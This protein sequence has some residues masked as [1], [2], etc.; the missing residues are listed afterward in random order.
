VSI[1]PVAS[2]AQLLPA[3]VV[4][5]KVA[6][7]AIG[8]FADML[9]AAV[10]F[11]PNGSSPVSQVSQPPGITVLPT[12]LSSLLRDF[13]SSFNQLLKNH[14]L[15][16]G[17]GVRLRLSELGDV[18]VAGVHPRGSVIQNLLAKTPQ[19]AELFR[20]IAA[21]ATAQRKAQEFAAFQENSRG[22]GDGFPQVFSQGH[23]PKFQMFLEGDSATT[24]FV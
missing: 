17:Q 12:E 7:K 24:A 10:D 2:A 14:E 20:S 19:L 9:R 5:G 3:A 13:A 15:D 8:S 23:S 21:K 18:E 11:P 4:A 1:I 16:S 22:A 6:T